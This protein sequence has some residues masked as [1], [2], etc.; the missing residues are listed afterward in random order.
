[1]VDLGKKAFLKFYVVHLL[2]VDNLS[3]F[4]GLQGDWFSVKQ[5]QIHFAKRSRPNHSDQVEVCNLPIRVL[6]VPSS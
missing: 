1:M 6:N 3:L 5:G 2:Q 4:E